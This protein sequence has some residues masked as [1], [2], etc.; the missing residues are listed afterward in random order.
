MVYAF[1]LIAHGCCATSITHSYYN[2]RGDEAYAVKGCAKPFGKNA[3]GNERADQLSARVNRHCN[4]RAQAKFFKHTLSA[5]VRSAV[6]CGFVLANPRLNLA[7]LKLDRCRKLRAHT[8]GLLPVEM[9]VRVNCAPL[10]MPLFIAQVNAYAAQ[11]PVAQ[12]HV[13]ERSADIFGRADCV[14]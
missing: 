4:A 10:Q 2:G 5:P 7:P 1:V 3:G 14:G 9:L 13:C 8:S 11:V 12:D 6:A